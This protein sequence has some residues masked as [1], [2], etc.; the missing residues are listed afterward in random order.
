MKAAAAGRT[1]RRKPVTRKQSRAGVVVSER[2]GDVENK[3]KSAAVDVEQPSG[4][5]LDKVRDILF[6]VQMRENEKRF[7]RLEERLAKDVADIRDDV[8]K[9]LLALES[10]AKKEVASLE[11]RIGGEQESRAAQLKEVSREIKDNAK[12]FDKKTASLDDQLAKSQK[13]LRQQI[14][15]LHQ[16]LSD[17]LREKSEAILASLSREAQEL[18]TEKADRATLAALFTEVAMRLNNEFKLPGSE[19][20]G[21]G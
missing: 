15:D 19:K 13:E 5:S 9:R 10:Y 8:K 18:R 11:E 4:A 20:S 21:D 12:S 14:L 2:K 1:T 3:N 16:R 6:G 17:D 7:A